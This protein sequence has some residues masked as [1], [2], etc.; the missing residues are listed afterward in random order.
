MS[1]FAKSE[2]KFDRDAWT[3]TDGIAWPHDVPE[4]PCWSARGT[5][6]GSA[7][8]NGPIWILGG[9]AYDTPSTPSRKFHYDVCSSADGV[10]W[11]HLR[12]Q[13]PGSLG[14]ITTSPPGTI[15][16]GW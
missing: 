9:G 7:V 15:G 10:H 14:N 4:E 16:C 13:F 11:Q 2:E 3:T 12:Q 5:I 1:A 8:M 6:G